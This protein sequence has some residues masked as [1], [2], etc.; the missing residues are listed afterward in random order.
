MVR[1][2]L[3]FGLPKSLIGDL[4]GVHQRAVQRLLLAGW[5]DRVRVRVALRLRDCNCKLAKVAGLSFED[6]VSFVPKL[7]CVV[8]ACRLNASKA[9][10]AKVKP[11]RRLDGVDTILR[12][13]HTLCVLSGCAL[14]S[15]CPST[16]ADSNEACLQ[17]D[18]VAF[19][20]NGLDAASARVVRVPSITVHA[21]MLL[22]GMAD[23]VLNLDE[24]FDSRPRKTG[25]ERLGNARADSKV[26]VRLVGTP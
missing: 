24:V 20:V 4:K 10:Q 19:V 7:F 14:H 12:T 2:K 18:S 25:S 17:I 15:G 13:N 3:T 6:N 5:V 8:N 23:I 21:F 1:P 9:F 16:L 26:E 11:N 22:A